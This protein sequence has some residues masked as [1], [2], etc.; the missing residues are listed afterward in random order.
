M[1]SWSARRGARADPGGCG[2]GARELVGRP[3]GGADGPGATGGSGG[4]RRSG[5]GAERKS[6]GAGGPGSGGADGVT[7]WG[8][9]PDLLVEEGV[10]APASWVSAWPAAASAARSSS[11]RCRRVSGCSGCVLTPVVP[12]TAPTEPSADG[13]PR[14]SAPP[15]TPP[16]VA[17]YAPGRQD[18]CSHPLQDRHG[19][20]PAHGRPP[21]R[22]RGRSR[23][24]AGTPPADPGSP[25]PGARARPARG[26]ARPG[27]D[28]HGPGRPNVAGGR[29]AAWSPSPHQ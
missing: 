29:H 28:R 23:R 6:P 9:C 21:S 18:S 20:V 13:C 16:R 4:P 17:R 8:S 14:P 1:G 10:Q 11:R 26:H 2:S 15:W 5:D 24:G 27:R 22:A 12:L 7:G 25:R 19:A 3:P